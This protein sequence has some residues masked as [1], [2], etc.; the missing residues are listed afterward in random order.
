[1]TD[2]SRT[3]GWRYWMALNLGIFLAG[4]TSIA[5]SMARV[6]DATEMARAGANRKHVTL[7]ALDYQQRLYSFLQKSF[8]TS[9]QI[10]EEVR[11]YIGELYFTGRELTLLENDVYSGV[12]IDLGQDIQP[13]SEH[14]V[15]YGLRVYKKRFQMRQFPFHDRYLANNEIDRN[16]VFGS[17]SGRTPEAR[18]TGLGPA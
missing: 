15:F 14:S 11:E 6:S 16:V 10:D 4:V 7:N 13:D 9:R 5:V 17:A 2:Q 3:R 1:M 8:G 18:K 12:L